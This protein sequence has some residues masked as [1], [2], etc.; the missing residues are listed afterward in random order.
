[1]LLLN[2]GAEFTMLHLSMETDGRSCRKSKAQ[3]FGSVR[4]LLGRL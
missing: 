4:G 3:T 2:G 1:M